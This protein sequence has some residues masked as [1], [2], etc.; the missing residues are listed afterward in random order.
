MVS[1]SGA[2]RRAQKAVKAEKCA[3][4]G[5]EDRPQRHHVNGDV[6]DNRAENL[7]ALCQKC[8]T[9]V[10]MMI[11]NWGKGRVKPAICQVCGVMFQP[12]RSRRAKMCGKEECRR[13]MGR[14]SAA[15]RWSRESLQESSTE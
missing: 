11:G 3:L 6:F 8:H 10:H 4:C 5:S 13:E 9:E 2:R 15:H 1:K 12:K 7:K 14:R